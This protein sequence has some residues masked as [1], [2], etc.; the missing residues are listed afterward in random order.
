MA[1]VL[2][3]PIED[4]E[5]VHQ[6]VCGSYGILLF[7]TFI[8]APHVSYD[9]ILYDVPDFSVSTLL[10]TVHSES[11]IGFMLLYCAETL[12]GPA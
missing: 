11:P 5:M 6:V 9:A 3:L 12:I 7:V 2:P 1:S 10:V 8:L 4:K